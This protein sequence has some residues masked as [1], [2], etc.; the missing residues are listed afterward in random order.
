MSDCGNGSLN[1]MSYLAV[2]MISGVHIIGFII[3]MIGFILL[4]IVFI[5]GIIG[6]TMLT[7]CF[8]THTI[9]LALG[10]WPL[11]LGLGSGPGCQSPR[12]RR[13]VLGAERQASGA[14]CWA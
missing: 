7:L 10:H 13:W 9:G 6:S 2:F 5:I 4:F 3:H 1:V 8:I 12:V 11:T 14:W